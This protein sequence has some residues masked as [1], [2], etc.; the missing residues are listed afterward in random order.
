MNGSAVS[1]NPYNGNVEA[2]V[3]AYK[4]S[5]IYRLNRAEES[6]RQPG[7]SIKGII[8]AL[9]LEKKIITPSSIVKDEKN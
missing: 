7:S 8:F 9:A 6:K 1:L 2:L 5:S 3:G 4:I